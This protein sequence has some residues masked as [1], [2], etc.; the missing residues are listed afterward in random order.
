MTNRVLTDA[1]A[2]SRDKILIPARQTQPNNLA[3]E[4]LHCR[5]RIA[6]DTDDFHG[7][8]TKIRLAEACR[9]E[10]IAARHFHIGR[11]VLLF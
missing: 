8:P 4:R 5:R 6:M 2:R 1:A 3:N 10:P 9:E 11:F 7:M